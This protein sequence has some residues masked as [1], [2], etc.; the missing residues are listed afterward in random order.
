MSETS[1]TG[2]LTTAAPSPRRR[3][4]RA[5][6]WLGPSLRRRV[7]LTLLGAFVLVA[8]VLAV[9]EYASGADPAQLDRVIASFGRGVMEQLDTI[10]DPAEARGAVE[11]L[12]MQINRSYREAGLPSRLILQ[13]RDRHGQLLHGTPQALPALL[14]ES[15][16]SS[17]LE[18]HGQLLHV[19][20]AQDARWRI[21]V[22]QPEV[23]RGWRIRAIADDLAGSLLI[24]LP[25]VLLPLWFAVTQGLRP[26]SQLSERIRLREP[27]DLDATGIAPRHAELQPLVEALD[28]LLARLRRK[29]QRERAFV[30]DAAHEL[31]TPLAVISAQA[32]A[33]ARARG[34]A[35]REQ[36]QTRLDDAIAR[37]SSLI[38]QLLQ[39]ARFDGSAEESTLLDVARVAQEELAV[40]EPQAFAR[41]LELSL[42]APDTL[43]WP[44]PLGAFRAILQNLAGNA[45]RYVQAGGH[46][47][48][49]LEVEID[50]TTLLMSVTDDGPGIPVP[51]RATVFERFVR[52]PGHD[53][54][55]SGLGLAI[56]RQAAARA[57]GTVRLVDGLTGPSGARGCRFEVV[58]TSRVPSQRDL[59]EASLPWRP[60][61]HSGGP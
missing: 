45:V 42:E 50:G 51:L 25:L 34:A 32:H 19:F 57:G 61:S 5:M 7:V 35:E 26:L 36:A 43:T 53:V 56:V 3:P 15:S 14:P 58:F 13:L 16:G 22:A 1:L 6:R 39:L 31:R 40:L 59:A 48:I 18:D 9:R 49:A 41:G 33:L 8:V 60:R 27:D 38:D 11:S 20:Q 17:R 29:V 24:A 21:A 54:A 4:A 46:V 28:A 37:S 44:M 23:D 12:E 10:E 55:G 52:G 30:H 47:A 2:L